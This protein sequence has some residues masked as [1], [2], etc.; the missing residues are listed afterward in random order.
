MKVYWDL[1]SNNCFK[2]KM[3]L[4]ILNY[5]YEGV[6]I[7]ILKGETK[8]ANFL[9]VNPQGKLPVLITDDQQTL[10]ESNAIL[11]YLAQDTDYFPKNIWAQS[12][13]MQWMFFEQ[14]NHQPNIAIARVIKKYLGL[15]SEN[16]AEYDRMMTEGYKALAIMEV[17]LGNQPYF[18]EEKPTITDLALYPATVVAEEGGFELSKFKNIVSWLR[19]I[20][21][22]PNCPRMAA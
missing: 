14:Y 11:F 7:D 8:Q 4:D 22:L 18:V 2:I 15:T 20:E 16:Q 3:L 21:K 13:I 17:H 19:R 10:I 6:S 1:R 12:Q 9:E 5:P